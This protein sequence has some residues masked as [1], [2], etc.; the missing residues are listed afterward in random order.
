MN[1]L[2]STR[3]VQS[4]GLV[5]RYCSQDAIGKIWPTCY[6]CQKKR[7]ALSVIIVL[8]DWKL[9]HSN[10]KL[11]VSP[12]SSSPETWGVRI[13]RGISTASFGR[14]RPKSKPALSAV[15]H[16]FPCLFRS[17]IRVSASRSTSVSFPLEVL[18]AFLLN[19]TAVKLGL[20]LGGWTISQSLMIHGLRNKVLSARS[21]M[22]GEW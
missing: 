3:A 9:K 7:G 13:D 21:L 14:S 18:S 10:F 22:S 16:C 11:M 5:Q 4:C 1:Q 2:P 6:S 8:V 17:E 15:P 20:V 12:V 19:P